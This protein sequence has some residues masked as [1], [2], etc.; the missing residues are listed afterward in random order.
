MTYIVALTGGIGSGKTTVSDCFK[1][2]GVNVI[3]TDI[4]AKNIIEK[5]VKISLIIA[6]KIGKK[7]LNYNNSINRSLLRKHIFENKNDR[8]WLENLLHP[9][10]YQ[11]SQN[12]IKLL[13][14]AWC[15]WVV[16]LLI[17]KKLE[18]KPDRILLVDTTI[19][20]QIQRI[21]KRDKI[22]IQEARRMISIQASRKTRIS[23][24]DD[25]I[26]NKNNIKKISQ[27]VEYLNH[28]YSYLSKKHNYNQIINT[29]KN[30]LTKFF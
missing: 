28:F 20:R 6:Q 26:F 11:E 9:K 8:L 7:I 21:I 18:K 16:P 5:N 15:L 10:I 1:K 30:Y 22:N 24:S 13:K 3:D 4:I 2:I 27:C 23:I 14:S 25:I 19:N 12:Q 17:E 29:K